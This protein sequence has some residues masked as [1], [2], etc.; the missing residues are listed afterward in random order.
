MLI[1]ISLAKNK[2]NISKNLHTLK[3]LLICTNGTNY[4]KYFDVKNVYFLISLLILGYR[5]SIQQ[6]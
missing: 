1:E 6:K 4:E 3:D 2:I 5:R